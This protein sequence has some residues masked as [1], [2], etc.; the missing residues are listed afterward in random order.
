MTPITLL[1]AASALTAPVPKA[2]PRAGHIG[3]VKAARCCCSNPTAKWFT[4]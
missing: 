3:V 2:A 4:G 1:L